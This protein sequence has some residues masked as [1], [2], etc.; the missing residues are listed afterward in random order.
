LELTK[1]A[2]NLR[3]E[4]EEKN[5]QIRDK[6]LEAVLDPIQPYVIPQPREPVPYLNFSPL[7]NSFRQL[8]DK[9][10]EYRD[11]VSA[12]T[13]KG[14]TMPREVQ[15]S[16]DEV[17]MKTERALTRSEGLP[18]RPWFK[19]QI[20]APGF[21]TGYD[22][23]TLPAVREA[24]EERNWKDVDEQVAIVAKTLDRFADEI[25]RATKLV[26]QSSRD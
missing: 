25:D 20:Y 11:A 3:T 15:A 18:R 14:Q 1:L 19:H 13:A 26:K 16:M 4:T 9:E 12:L 17:L 7:Q 22:V 10:K 2:D 6:T 21:Y 24:I 8:Q 5:R 23:K